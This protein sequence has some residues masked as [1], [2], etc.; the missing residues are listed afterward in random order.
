MNDEL[1]KLEYFASLCLPQLVNQTY[2]SHAAELAYSYA[3][4]LVNYIEKQEKLKKEI[5]NLKN[6]N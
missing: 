1:T 6:K 4:C 3:E 2:P 5:D